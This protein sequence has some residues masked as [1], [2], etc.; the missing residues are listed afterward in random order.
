MYWE[1]VYLMFRKMISR[2]SYIYH[3]LIIILILKDYPGDT[4]RRSKDYG[5]KQA[6][7]L[8]GASNKLEI[9]GQQLELQVW[10][11]LQ[12]SIFVV[13]TCNLFS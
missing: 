10:R 4:L 11:L 9:R 5:S 8:R 12:V 3:L 6:G 2:A 1:R 7:K 13:K